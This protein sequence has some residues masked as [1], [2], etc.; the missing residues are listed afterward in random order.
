[1]ITSLN[2]AQREGLADFFKNAAV[3]WF[4]AAFTIPYLT[5]TY[6]LLTQLRYLASMVLALYI[7]MYLLKE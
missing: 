5:S 6:D 4:T 7:A 1:M 2:K 3:G